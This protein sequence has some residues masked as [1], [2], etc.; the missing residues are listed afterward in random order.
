MHGQQ[1]LKKGTGNCKRK[2]Y[3]AFG[4]KL[5]FGRGYGPVARLTVE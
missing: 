4:G 1:N 3:F 5:I 2:H